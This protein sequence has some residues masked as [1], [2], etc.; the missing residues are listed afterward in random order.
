MKGYESFRGWWGSWAGVVR[1]GPGAEEGLGGG[2]EVLEERIK[3]KSRPQLYP[4]SMSEGNLNLEHLRALVV[5]ISH[6][7]YKS[8]E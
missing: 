1:K 7:W 3:L 5:Q 8:E 4:L 2:G 6:V